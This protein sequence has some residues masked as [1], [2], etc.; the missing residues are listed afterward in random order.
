M[1]VV[2][3]QNHY[4]NLAFSAV[5]G[6]WH[7]TPQSQD[8]PSG[9]IKWVCYPIYTLAL[10]QA[11]VCPN[12]IWFF[13]S[14]H[15]GNQ[16]SQEAKYSCDITAIYTHTNL[17][18]KLKWPYAITRLTAHY[19]C[20]LRFDLVICN[21]RK[22]MVIHDTECPYWDQVSLNNTN[23]TKSQDT[24]HLSVAFLLCNHFY[25]THNIICEKNV[26]KI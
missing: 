21:F 1:V 18:G 16:I 2:E 12:T 25:N 20:G 22:C 5:V 24:P 3:Y 26:T 6:L 8:T 10:L 19:M 15:L 9:V 17:R 11:S 13:V 23:Q 14:W 7:V 4:L